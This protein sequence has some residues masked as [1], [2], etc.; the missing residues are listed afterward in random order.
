MAG[1]LREVSALDGCPLRK[2]SLYCSSLVQISNN[3]SIG[4]CRTAKTS[5]FPEW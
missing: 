4:D 1:T 5:F 2:S 3:A